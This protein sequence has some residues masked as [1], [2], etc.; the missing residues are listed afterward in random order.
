V[1]SSASATVNRV[2]GRVDASFAVDTSTRI[3]ALI[4]GN[5]VRSAATDDGT[6][7]WVGGATSGV[8]AI[9]FGATGGTAIISG[10][11][12]NVRVVDVFGGQLYG[13]SG[14]GAFTNVFAIGSGLPTAAGQTATSLAGMP[15]SGASP[16]A[17]VFFD[18]DA[19]IPGLDRLYVADDR[20]SP[21]GGVQRWSYNAATSQWV[22]SATLNQVTSGGAPAFMAFRGVT[23]YVSS[24]TTVTLIATGADATT[25]N[26]LVVFV[27]D[28]TS[29]PTGTK[30]T[31][32]P[33]NT[34]F[35]G[36]ALVPQ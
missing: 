1:A 19:S 14:S 10:L 8:V 9:P 31:A 35:R 4:S 17:Y 28:G 30:I 26:S 23:G 21:N 2:V 27:D 20:A 29:T 33:T 18:L 36:I 5:N 12:T 3:D 6:R 25:A 16:Y 15:T 22:L 24:G 13:T 11:P 32:A 34:V 7:F